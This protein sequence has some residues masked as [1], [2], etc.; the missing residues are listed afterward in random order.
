MTYQHPPLSSL[1]VTKTISTLAV[2]AP[3]PI[4]GASDWPTLICND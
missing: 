2:N 3:F 1:P 4:V